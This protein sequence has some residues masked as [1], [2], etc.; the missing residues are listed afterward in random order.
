MLVLNILIL[1]LSLY[2][3]I[4]FSDIF[5]DASTSMAESFKVPKMVIALTVAAFSTCVPELAI[6]FNS[7][8]SG[9]V[10]MTL[11]NVIGS[12]I[13]NILLIIGVSAIVKP[14]K[15]KGRTIR[16]E[17][18]LLLLITTAFFF[19]MNDSFFKNVVN[20]LGRTDGIIL[21]ILFIIFCLY[22]VSITRKHK[23]DYEKEPLYTKKQSII[24][25]L[26]TI[27]GIIVTSDLIVD[28]AVFIAE[29]LHISQKFIAMTIIVIGTS[30]PELTITVLSAKKGEFDM[31]IGN[32]IGTNIFNI[33]IVLG[34][35][36]TIFGAVS[37]TSFNLIDL[38]IVLLAALLLTLFG[39]SDRELTRREGL[40]MLL[41]VVFY[42]LYLFIM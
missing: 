15:L 41:V 2:L 23:E 42:Y 8:S 34:L 29:S 25:M 38:L 9:N 6:S 5:V 31:A 11:A 21:I 18:P 17:L 39:R 3:I 30:L 20:S 12:C 16:R 19:L 14:I 35:P 27:I 37:S 4:K 36:I 26:C 40:V 32:I 7:I 22:I 13:I 28:S 1:L 33:C 24:I 10:D